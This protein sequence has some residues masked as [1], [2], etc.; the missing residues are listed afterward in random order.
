MG[1]ISASGVH[2]FSHYRPGKDVFLRLEY[3][4]A[5]ETKVRKTPSPY[6]SRKKCLT[7]RCPEVRNWTC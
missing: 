6:S 7:V 4:G 2:D 5:S 3:I 1:D